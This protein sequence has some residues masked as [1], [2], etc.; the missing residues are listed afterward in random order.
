[1]KILKP[2]KTVVGTAFVCGLVACGP[3]E[4][5]KEVE[6]DGTETAGSEEEVPPV[7]PPPAIDL[8]DVNSRPVD[9]NG[10]SA[11]DLEMLNMA[12]EQAMMRNVGSAGLKGKTMEEQMNA[13]PGDSLQINSV[14]DMV[15][16]GLIKEAPK[17]PEG[18]K[19]VVKGGAVVLE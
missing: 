8:A 12:L 19:Y 10:N 3:G 4:V 15:K 16:H 18:K 11:S 5:T 7:E 17:A 13:S 6:Y 9:E 2:L 1:M 14:E